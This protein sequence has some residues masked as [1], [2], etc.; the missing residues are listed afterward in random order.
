MIKLCFIVEF[1]PTFFLL[2]KN[3][4]YMSEVSAGR[5]KESVPFMEAVDEGWREKHGQQM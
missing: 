4:Q 3:G 1:R 2:Y 5:E